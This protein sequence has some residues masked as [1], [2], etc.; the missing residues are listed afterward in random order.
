MIK[1]ILSLCIYYC[2]QLTQANRCPIPKE[3]TKNM[4]EV[5]KVLEPLGWDVYRANTTQVK[6]FENQT[7][8]NNLNG[9]LNRSYF[10]KAKNEYSDYCDSWRSWNKV[11]R[12]LK[13]MELAQQ[14]CCCDFVRLSSL[15]SDVKMCWMQL[16]LKDKQSKYRWINA[17]T[18]CCAWWS[19]GSCRFNSCILRRY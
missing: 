13:T 7:Y 12:N 1:Y 11:L 5:K 18:H 2:S 15:N 9:A 14:V 8:Q 17:E 16:V 10:P 19:Q 6:N 3:A 4:Q